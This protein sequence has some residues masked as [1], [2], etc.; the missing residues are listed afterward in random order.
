MEDVARR[1]GVTKGTVYLYFPGKEA[2]FK[3]VV[4]ETIVRE[5]ER[6]E[7]LAETHTGS[8][9]D[10]LVALM[11]SWWAAVGETRLAGLLKLVMAESSNFPELAEFYTTEVVQRGRRLFGRVLQR[12]VETGEFRPV[13]VEVAVRVL[14]APLLHAATWRHS[15]QQCERTNLE[16]ESYLTTHIDLVMH[17]LAAERRPAKDP[18]D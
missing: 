14:I 6:G 12:G 8:A 18:T 4:R 3:S 10:L 17:G 1:A 5:I 13:R 11:R 9:A 2:L 15:L 16:I 7:A